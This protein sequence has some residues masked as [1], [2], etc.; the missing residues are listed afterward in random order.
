MVQ[1]AEGGRGAPRGGVGLTSAGDELLAAVCDVAVGVARLGE[2]E[3]PPVPAPPPL[4]RFLPMRR[5]P[6]A[7]IAA[8]RGVLDADAAFRARVADAVPEEAAVGRAG[9]LFVHRPEGWEDE[10]GELVAAGEAARAAAEEAHEEQSARRRLPAVEEKLQRTEAA[11]SAAVAEATRAQARASGEARARQAAENDAR[12]W[13]AKAEALRHERDDAR[14]R[15]RR[16]GERH[17]EEVARLEARVAELEAAVAA[18]RRDAAA[19]PAPSGAPA[20]GASTAPGEVPA[21]S[22]GPPAVDLAA[23][24]GALRAASAALAQLGAALASAAAALGP[25]AEVPPAPPA[26]DGE[27]RPARPA[28]PPRRQPVRLPGGVFED[29]PEAAEH[30]VR[31]PGAVLLVDGYNCTLTDLPWRDL[32]V[33]EQRRR[34]VDALTELATRTGVDVEVVFDGAEVA[35][36]PLVPSVGRRAVR[37]TFSDPAVEADDVVIARAAELPVD[38]PVVVASSDNRV[39]DGARRSGANVIGAEQLMALLR[40]R[41]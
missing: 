41:R 5:L 12:S 29:S 2:R 9:W 35:G 3:D 18:A 10:F 7:A 38:R 36:G 28:P 26:S 6:R 20:P 8:V 14:A 31:V 39:R 40:A 24:G 11:R 21:P 37:V 23:V 19:P 15:L 30:L 34:L 25:P 33:A 16:L 17:D 1:L 22:P 27:V 4:R 13:Q 32:P